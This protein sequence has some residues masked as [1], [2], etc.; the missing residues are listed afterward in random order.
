MMQRKLYTQFLGHWKVCTVQQ[1]KKKK[2]TAVLA[3]SFPPKGGPE[4][5]FPQ[6]REVLSLTL[7]HQGCW[8]RPVTEPPRS[9]RRKWVGKTWVGKRGLV[10]G[11]RVL[12]SLLQEAPLGHC[13]EVTWPSLPTQYLYFLLRAWLPSVF[14]AQI[15]INQETVSR[16]CS[17]ASIP[18]SS[19]KTNSQMNTPETSHQINSVTWTK[20]K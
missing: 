7:P 11:P 18:N 15:I 10:P 19:F 20:Q 17:V 14:S 16:I 12:G 2:A 1:E 9:S 4:T 6:A 3:A 5:A 13:T 8:K